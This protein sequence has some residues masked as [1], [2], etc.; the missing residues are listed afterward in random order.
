MKQECYAHAM[1]RNQSN[2]SGHQT[3]SRRCLLRFLLLV[4]V[5]VMGAAPL[6]ALLLTRLNVR[7]LHGEDHQ[8]NAKKR[9]GGAD[10]MCVC[11]LDCNAV[12][13]RIHVAKECAPSNDHDTRMCAWWRLLFHICNRGSSTCIYETTIAAHLIS[14]RRKAT[15]SYL[16]IMT[17]NIRFKSACAAKNQ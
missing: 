17:F 10:T 11:Y 1:S 14:L 8:S 9:G 2:E 3:S 6:L 4:A 13:K 12:T 16:E 15:W 5:V 7:I